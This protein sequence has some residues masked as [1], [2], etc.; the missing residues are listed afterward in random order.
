MTNQLSRD[1]G[2]TKETT[3]ETKETTKP[4]NKD[5]LETK[6]TKETKEN[7]KDKFS[8]E[9]FIHILSTKDLKEIAEENIVEKEIKNIDLVEIDMDRSSISED[10]YNQEFHTVN[11]LKS[12]VI[13]EFY[14]NKNF[15]N[16]RHNSPMCDLSNENK[17]KS[18]A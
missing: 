9:S 10:S 12:N 11:N 2:G 6:E 5:T 17:L 16:F 15:S 13:S 18:R 1:T 3:K 8:A 4:T 14:S 7:N